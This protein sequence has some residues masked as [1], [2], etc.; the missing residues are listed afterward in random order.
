[1][2]AAF[3]INW[4]C[5]PHLPLDVVLGL[6]RAA[7]VAA[8]EIRNDLPGQEFMDGIPAE[9]LRDKLDAAGMEVASV[10]ALQRF[11]H[12]TPEREAEARRLAAYAAALEAPGLVLCPVID[13]G[14]GWSASD[15][16][17]Q[18]RAA[19]R[20][21]R[22]ILLDHGLTGYVEPLGMRGSTLR[23]QAVAVEAIGDAEAWDAFALCH[24]TFQVFR[25]G[26]ERLFPEYVGLVHVSGVLR[27]DLAPEDLTEPDRGFVF[28][29]D[30]VGNVPQ[31]RRLLAAGF[32]GYVSMEPF[33]PETQRDPQIATRL[34]ES[35]DHLA[36]ELAARPN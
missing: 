30:R 7:G 32:E 29:G 2:T 33:S 11:N 8:I 13:S 15:L 21:L 24:D 20:A 14:H 27:P 22:P 23:Q 3:A 12:W 35:L 5:A 16:A 1:V 6:A 19:L 17:R 10:N 34:R 4:S 9:V 26:D 18:I 28:E 36:A 25:S 31:L